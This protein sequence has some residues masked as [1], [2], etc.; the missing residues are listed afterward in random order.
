MQLDTLMRDVTFDVIPDQ[1]QRFERMGF[2]CVWTFESAHDPFLPLALS[3]AAT[4]R[5]HIGTNISVAFGRSPFAMAQVAWDLQKGS[6]G[7]LHLGL[8]T[9]VR[10]HVERRFSM[11]FE[12]PAAR[13]TDYIRCVR[14]IWDTFQ[15]GSRANYEG[16][17]YRFKLI[18]PFFNPGPIEHP[19]IPIYLAGVNPRMCRAAGE[20]ADGFHVHP[21]HSIG[22]LK[23]VVRPALDEGARLSGRTVDDLVLYAPVF[24]VSGDTQAEMDA[25]AQEVRRQVAFYGST[26]SY[27][28]LLQYHGYGSL[29]KQ[30]SDLMRKGDM[31]AMPKL[32]PDALLEAVAVVAS[33]SDLPVKLRQRYEGILQRVSLYFPIAPTASETA[34][35][36]FVD[37]FRATAQT[38]SQ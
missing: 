4:E 3:A 10:A 38:F 22:Y 35:K 32:V 5:L 23:D 13:V 9:Q 7:R 18:N 17:F 20:V 14:A 24:A 19:H 29:G 34:W 11:P 27:R 15:N 36:R 6:G 37:T 2:D 12:H 21:M 8:G 1:A 16:P 26:P 33:T 25:A 28:V 30:L 31:A